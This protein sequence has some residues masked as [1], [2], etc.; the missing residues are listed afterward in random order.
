MVSLSQE[1]VL[2]IGDSD[3]QVFTAVAQAMPAAQVRSVATLFDGIAELSQE[4]YTTVLASAEPLERRPEAAMRTLRELSGEGRL[5]L[6]GHPTLEPLAQKML[7]FGCDDYVILPMTVGELLETLGAPTLRIRAL[8]KAKEVDAEAVSEAE[9]AELAKPSDAENAQP[10]PLADIS[11]ADLVLEALVDA[12]QDSAGGVIRKINAA[13][14][15]EFHVSA[16]AP[17]AAVPETAPGLALISQSPIQPASTAAEGNTFRQTLHLTYPENHDR[18]I[19]AAFLADLA[20]RL[21]KVQTLQERHAALQRLAV[22]DDLTGL[23]NGRYFRHFLTKIIEKAFVMRF[24]VTLFLFDIDNFKKYNDAYGHG[25][26]DEILKQTAAL[27]KR[28]VRDHDLVARISGDEFAVVFWEKEG[29]RQPR[30]PGKGHPARVPIGPQLI[31]DRFRRLL[32]TQNFPQ[33]GAAGKGQLTISGGIAVYPWNAQDVTS[34]IEEADKQL[35]FGAKRGGRN[36]I[37]LVGGSSL[38]ENPQETDPAAGTAPD[39]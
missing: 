30:E 36:S 31:L 22:T 35:M 18:R 27:M 38:P 7:E 8:D 10:S 37:Q 6:F 3:R 14:P 16:D 29:P 4:P 17:T 2:L 19:A 15:P 5:L 11:V 39:A 34:L 21:A 25:V 26:G 9:A 13:L 24:A 1:R 12:P 20:K 32:A 23:Y 33:L 28:C